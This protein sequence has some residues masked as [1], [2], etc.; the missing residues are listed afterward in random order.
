MK[1]EVKLVSMQ[2]VKK[3]KTISDKLKLGE[4]VP[5]LNLQSN[6]NGNVNL[7]NLKQRKNL[8]IIFYHGF[9]CVHCKKK[10]K[11]LAE[12]YPEA[13]E[14]EAEIL[15]V[16]FDSLAKTRDY[17]K[18]WG[19]PFPLL[20]DKNREATEK[21]TYQDEDRK[22]PFPALFITDRFGVL[23]YQKI[24]DEADGLPDA[25]EILSWLLLIQTECPECSHL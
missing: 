24:V 12:V 16:S 5:Y 17:A 6:R 7:W 14:L 25:K 2:F 3:M 13:Q 9:Q 21:F 8:I 18:D 1:R 11:E 23:R 22:A 4:V 15:A 19:V 10:L 20:S